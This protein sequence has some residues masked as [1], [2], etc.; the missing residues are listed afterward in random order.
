MLWSCPICFLH[1][2]LV[3]LLQTSQWDRNFMAAH[4]ETDCKMLALISMPWINQSS[5]Y[6]WNC[7][8][9]QSTTAELEEG[10]RVWDCALWKWD[11]TGVQ[12]LVLSMHLQNTKQT[13]IFK[14]LSWQNG[15]EYFQNQ[16]KSMNSEA[17]LKFLFQS[18]STLELFS[19]AIVP[20]IYVVA[21]R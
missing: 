1:L 15:S 2:R 20:F 9:M 11:L 13:K 8:P 12:L 6:R 18:T 19:N 17:V 16:Q 4:L 7:L 5:S 21:G 10:M 3:R 14:F